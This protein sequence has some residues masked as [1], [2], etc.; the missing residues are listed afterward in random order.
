[1]LQNMEI[2]CRDF[3]MQ[4]FSNKCHPDSIYLEP[5]NGL[6]YFVEGESIGSDFGFPRVDIKKRYRW[7]KMNFTTDL[8]KRKPIVSYIVASAVRC[9]RFFSDFD[10]KDSFRMH[11]VV[12]ANN[13]KYI[14]CHIRK[15]TDTENIPSHAPKRKI[16]VP[17]KKIKREPLTP[18]D[19]ANGIEFLLEAAQSVRSPIKSQLINSPMIAQRKL[20]CDEID[21]ISMYSTL[22]KFIDFDVEEKP[23]FHIIR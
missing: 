17:R 18:M 19:N 20:F 21:Y 5:S 11:A 7:K 9:E 22:N 13:P 16:K 8:P 15:I 2:Y 12:L 23:T 14:L 4:S 6:I 1:M 3:G 10:S